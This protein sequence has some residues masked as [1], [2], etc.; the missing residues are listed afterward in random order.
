MNSR[1]NQFLIGICIAAFLFIIQWVFGIDEDIFISVFL[2]IILVLLAGSLIYIFYVESYQRKLGKF[3]APLDFEEAE[4]YISNIKTLLQTAKGR[5]LRN[6]LK[7]NLAVGYITVHQFDMALTI[8][9]GL[10]HERLRITK[11]KLCC[12]LNL[13][14]SYIC[15]KQYDKAVE[16]YRANLNFLEPFRKDKVYGGNI[17]IMQ[18]FEA[19]KNGQY[20]IAERQ[21]QIAQQTWTSPYL[22][23]AFQ[24]LEGFILEPKIWDKLQE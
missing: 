12:L 16:L 11:M 6:A 24:L 5:N 10:A 9:E 18:I 15:T 23:D 14:I 8:L 2:I 1:L 7:M 22:Q 21:L 4:E 20:E 19:I 3:A 13:Y 17:A